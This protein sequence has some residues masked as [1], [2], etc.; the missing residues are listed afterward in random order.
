MRPWHRRQLVAFTLVELLVVIG[1]IALLIAVL[2]PALS[3][4]REQAKIAACLS[5]VRQLTTAWIMYANDNKGFLVFAETD[6]FSAVPPPAGMVAADAG[7]I[8]WVIDVPGDPNFN[9]P[10]AVRAGNLW[11]Y[12]KNPETSRCPS[13]L[14]LINW[15]SYSICSNLNGARSLHTALYQDAPQNDPKLPVQ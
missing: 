9:S 3:K 2:L 12:C 1:I 7:N 14:D 11:K 13:S 6:D 4:A 15:R 5:N 10:G 8:G